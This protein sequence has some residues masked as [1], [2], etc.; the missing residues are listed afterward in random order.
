MQR[1]LRIHGRTIQYM[2]RRS[3]RVRQLR[4]AVHHD[5]RVVVTVPVRVSAQAAGQFLRE[6]AEWV[7][8]KLEYFRK[9]SQD[10]Q[11]NKEL[12]RQLVME[13]IKFFNRF[14]GFRF[15][16]VRIRNQKTRWGS[17]STLGNLNF[18]Y[19]IVDLP[20]RMADYI[21]VHELCHLKQMNHSPKF[22]K[23]VAQTIPDYR[24]IKKGLIKN[25]LRLG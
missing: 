16:Q 2:L 12:A 5:G 22:W 7:K 20:K 8:Q 25:G 24:E 21:I 1:E 4:I 3:W 14:Y 15:N 11:R 18:N 9:S 19:K 10:F 17:C 6:K 13:R 23:L